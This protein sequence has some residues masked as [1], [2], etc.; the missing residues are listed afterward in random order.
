MRGTLLITNCIFWGNRD[1]D[2]MGELAQIHWS[3][4]PPVVNN[5][6]VQGGWSGDGGIG[7]IDQDP[8]FVRDPYDGGDGWGQGDNDDF[9]DLYLRCDSPCLDLGDS[10]ALPADVSDV[11]GDG[12]T[13]EQIPWDLDGTDR[14]V[15]GTV[16][17]GAYEGPHQGF[18][19]VGDPV[20]VP[21]GGTATFGVALSCA[22]GEVVSVSVAWL[23]G[24]EDISIVSGSE[25]EFDSND[26]SRYLTKGATRLDKT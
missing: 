4:E 22:P 8:R 10:Q 7:N 15:N 2:G 11:D 20:T 6:C 23:S 3:D 1:A 25:L 21:E 12:D 14:I 5:S 18:V 26:F 9:G 16:D 19:I 17:M 13:D 24:D